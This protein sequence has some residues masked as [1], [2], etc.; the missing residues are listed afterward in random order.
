MALEFILLGL[1][2][3]QSKVLF[4]Q[5]VLGWVVGF[6]VGL[7]LDVACKIEDDKTIK[8][9]KQK[10]AALQSTLGR[11]EHALEER[12]VAFREKEKTILSL[13]SSNKT[14]DNRKDG[15]D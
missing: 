13:R 14:L 6:Q 15:G 9:L 3:A 2:A 11:Y 12:E 8:S 10:V 7:G 1:V 5:E 4:H